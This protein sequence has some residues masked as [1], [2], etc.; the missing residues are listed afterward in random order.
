[1]RYYSNEDVSGIKSIQRGLTTLNLSSGIGETT[2]TN[3]T[4]TAVDMNKSVLV[5]N[6]STTDTEE[7]VGAPYSVRDRRLSAGSE[8]HI[9]SSTNVEV[10]W[11]NQANQSYGLTSYVQWQVVEYN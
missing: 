1:M 7:N 3:E 2:Q 9:T 10:N 4:I 11:K 6:S 8:A 5:G